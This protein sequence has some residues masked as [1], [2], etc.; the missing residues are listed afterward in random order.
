MEQII[1]WAALGNGRAA[2]GIRDLMG[3][4]MRDLQRAQNLCVCVC[5]CAP[6]LRD[7]LELVFATK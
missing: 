7:A 1:S 6:Y 3:L 2:N 5:V 4:L